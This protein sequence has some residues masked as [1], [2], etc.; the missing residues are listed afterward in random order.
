MVY[1]PNEPK[2]NQDRAE[3]AAKY[4]ARSTPIEEGDP[5]ALYLTRERG[6]PMSEVNRRVHMPVVEA[7][8]H[9]ARPA[10]LDDLLDVTSRVSERR[11]A[12]FTFKYEIH[13]AKRE[14]VAHGH[15]RHACWDPESK[16]ADR[17]TE[18]DDN[19]DQTTPADTP[20]SNHEPRV[21][22]TRAATP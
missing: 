9:Y 6:L 19:V 8:V 22:R 14:L 10:L 13:N 7:C 17:F 16:E 11:R 15:T 21:R 12:S 3:V 18:P 4:M 1:P 20:N 5:G 2:F